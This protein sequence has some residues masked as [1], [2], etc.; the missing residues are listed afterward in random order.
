MRLSDVLIL[1]INLLPALNYIQY[2]QRLF[3]GPI[4]D[5]IYLLLFI[6]LP[7]K[8]LIMNTLCYH[9]ASYILAEYFSQQLLVI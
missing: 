8:N 2:N 9:Y 1:I 4:T 6:P 7:C 5:G 3:Q